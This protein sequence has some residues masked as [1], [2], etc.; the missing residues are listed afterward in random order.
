MSSNYSIGVFGGTFDPIHYGH[1]RAAYEILYALNLN[2][3]RFIPC[4]DPYHR[5]QVFADAD[6]RLKMVSTAIKEQK[7]F[8]IDDREVRKKK[9]SYSIDTL[10]SLR[11]DFRNNSICLIIGMDVFLSLHKWHRWTEIL[12]FAHI[13]IAHRPGWSLPNFGKLGDLIKN[14]GTNNIKDLHIAT[15]GSIYIQAITQ[16]E[17]SSTE[18]RNSILKGLDSN[19]LVPDL[20]IDIIKE[21]NLYTSECNE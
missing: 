7:N 5:D 8:L 18:I 11:E 3:I 14:K 12:N 4:G 2:E 16:M 1:L 17:I 13:I 21:F 19:F 15:H 9:P 10:I 20:V 6:V